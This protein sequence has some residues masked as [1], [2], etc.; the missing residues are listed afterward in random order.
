[1]SNLLL[2]EKPSVAKKRYDIQLLK[3]KDELLHQ[4]LEKHRHDAQFFERNT[5]SWQVDDQLTA[6]NISNSVVLL[7]GSPVVGWARV[8]ARGPAS[9]SKVSAS[10]MV[11]ASVR[12]ASRRIGRQ[13]RNIFVALCPPLPPTH[14][15]RTELLSIG[16]P[17]VVG[18]GIRAKTLV[19][20]SLVM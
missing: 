17:H 9:A 8:C 6:N 15:H 16:C 19:S 7:A 13:R 20:R 14:S 12:T 5:T 10:W 4:Q 1:M 18:L 3:K 2:Q 11:V